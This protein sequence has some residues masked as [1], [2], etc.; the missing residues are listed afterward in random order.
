MQTGIYE[1]Y[2]PPDQ[3]RPKPG[4]EA[5]DVLAELFVLLENYAPSGIARSTIR[6]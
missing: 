1:L 2:R 5:A 4:Y 3:T 6:P